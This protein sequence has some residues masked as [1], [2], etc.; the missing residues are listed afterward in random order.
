MTLTKTQRAA[1]DDDS[2][3]ALFADTYPHEAYATWPERF[4][5]YATRK[6]G[7]SREVIERILRET[8]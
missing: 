1:L 7:Q 6:T 5:G 8:V 2:V 3:F 4:L